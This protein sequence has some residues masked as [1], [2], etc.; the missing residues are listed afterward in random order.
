MSRSFHRTQA[1]AAQT[2]RSAAAD[3]DVRAPTLLACP[4]PPAKVAIPV[5]TLRMDRTALQAA[6]YT[7]KELHALHQNAAQLVHPSLRQEVFAASVRSHARAFGASSKPAFAPAS[8]RLPNIKL[9]IGCAL[10]AL[11]FALAL[12]ASLKLKEQAT[13]SEAKGQGKVG[14]LASN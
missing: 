5:G 12:V 13:H 11:A 14:T 3:V 1:L 8:Q 6:L 10:F 4:G 2:F 9:A 7:K